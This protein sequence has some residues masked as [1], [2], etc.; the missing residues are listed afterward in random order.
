MNHTIKNLIPRLKQFAQKIEFKNAIVGKVWVFPE[1]GT[2][3][4]DYEFTS[5]GKLYMSINGNIQ[6]GKWEILPTGRIVIDRIVDKIILNFDFALD[7]IIILNKTS[8][9]EAPF[10]LYNKA[11]IPDGNILAHIENILNNPHK[12]GQPIDH[13]SPAV[14]ESEKGIFLFIC[15]LIIILAIIFS[16]V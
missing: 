6:I 14:D 4:H 10:L 12:I 13:E 2:A 9:D 5:D 11:I 3:I 8:R 1:Q 15:I 7:G 16:V